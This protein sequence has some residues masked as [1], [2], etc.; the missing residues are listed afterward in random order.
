MKISII[1]ISYNSISTIKNTIQSIKDQD[2]KNIEKIWIDNK[3]SDGTFEYLRKEKDK[4]T[5]L[6]SEK[7]DGI[8][9]AINKGIKLST[10]DIVCILNSDD[11]FYSDKILSNVIQEFNSHDI[12]LIF[13]DLLYVKGSKIIRTW[14]SKIKPNKTLTNID[15]SN[16]LNKGW[17]PPHPTLFIKKKFHENIGD[18][19]KQLKISAD[20]DYIIRLFYNKDLKVRYIPN[21]FIKMKVGGVSNKNLKNIL[22]KMKEDLYVIKK[23]RIGNIKTLIMKNFSK[24]NQFYNI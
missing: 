12:N 3:S 5:V 9:D 6:I 21:Y 23:N 18:Y 16:F 2:Y 7:D 15:F 17:M 19:D 13:G 22:N 11:E 8:Y 20:Y 4:N 10:G 14:K 24:L 1:T